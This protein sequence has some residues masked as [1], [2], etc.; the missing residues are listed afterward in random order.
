[1]SMI[2]FFYPEFSEIINQIMWEQ[3]DEMDTLILNIASGTPA[4]KSALVAMQSISEYP[5]RLVQVTTSNHV[6]NKHDIRGY[7]PILMWEY[8][9][10]NQPNAEN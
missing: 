5:C 10:D 8:N 7:P 1:M 2:L 4:M 3:M 9:E 6:M